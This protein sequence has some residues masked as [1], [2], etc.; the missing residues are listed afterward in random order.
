MWSKNAFL[1]IKVLFAI[2]ECGWFFCIHHCIIVNRAN[3]KT[4]AFITCGEG[5]WASRSL[6]TSVL[7][8][9]EIILNYVTLCVLLKLLIRCTLHCVSFFS[10]HRLKCNISFHSTFGQTA[11]KWYVPEISLSYI[12]IVKGCRLFV[13][14]IINIALVIFSELLIRKTCSY[15]P[16]F[17][18]ITLIHCY[19]YWEPQVQL[20]VAT[21]NN[22]SM[23]SWIVGLRLSNIFQNIKNNGTQWRWIELIT[24]T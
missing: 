21:A 22:F 9:H 12:I 24:W 19:Q 4:L 10:A 8:I 14:K 13:L 17:P 3:M 11:S 18:Y 2:S 5:E 20:N 6:L 1:N 15:F 23:T 7:F 16:N